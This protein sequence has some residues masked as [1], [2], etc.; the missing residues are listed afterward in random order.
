MWTNIWSISSRI[1]HEWTRTPEDI[2]WSRTR[3]GLRIPENGVER[4]CG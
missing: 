2:L 3:T 1:E 4:L